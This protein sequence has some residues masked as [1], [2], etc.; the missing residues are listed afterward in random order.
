MTLSQCCDAILLPDLDP[1]E[2]HSWQDVADAT[3]VCEVCG[4]PEQPLRGS[5]CCD[6]KLLYV[7][8]INVPGSIYNRTIKKGKR[9]FFEDIINEEVIATLTPSQIDEIMAI[10]EKAGY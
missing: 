3:L 6:P 1:E 4:E 5:G 10:L 2:S 9:M 8:V 7:T